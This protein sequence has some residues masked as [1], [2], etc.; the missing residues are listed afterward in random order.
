MQKNCRGKFLV[1]L[2]IQF[3]WQLETTNSRFWLINILLRKFDTLSEKEM[4]ITKTQIMWWKNKK[5]PKKFKKVLSNIFLWTGHTDPW[6]KMLQTLER[7]GNILV[8][9]CQRNTLSTNANYVGKFFA[10]YFAKYSKNGQT[11]C[12][13]FLPLLIPQQIL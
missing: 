11:I 5:M 8:S 10:V 6:C 3:H 4:K 13:L 2:S 7:G 1:V 12:T 9:F